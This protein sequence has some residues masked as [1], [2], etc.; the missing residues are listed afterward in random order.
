[1]P[2]VLG[3]GYG[4]IQQAIDGRLALRLLL[5]LVFA[6]MIAFA[7]TVSSGG[8]GGVFA[9]SLFVGAMVGGSLAVISHEP[10]AVFAVVGMAAVFGA[11]AR[12][13][14][15]TMLMVTEMA[16]G[17]HLLV[18]AGVAVMLSYLL[19]VRLS[20]FLKYR[21]LYEGQVPT[22]QDSPAHYSEHIQVA[23]RLLSS[24]NVPLTDELG[25]LS[26]LRL[27]RSR[28]RFD[29]PGGKQLTMGV[30]RDDSSL[31]G[32]TIA[33]LYRRLERYEFEIVAVARREHV[34]LPHP[35][36]LLEA[37]DR[38]ILITSPEAREPLAQYI[39]PLTA[40]SGTQQSLP[41]AAA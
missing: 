10:S 19:Q 32:K 27:L 9:P 35:G 34:L 28:I 5:I 8:S 24:R 20:S 16:G 7:L 29:L 40:E 18:P 2:Q 6:K 26:L 31:V 3:G 12:V 11:A 13:P 37:G 21:S 38:F 17:Y 41:G 1:V 25:H 39:S 22:R 15:A 30:L 23:L 36:T 4:W 14:V 33:D